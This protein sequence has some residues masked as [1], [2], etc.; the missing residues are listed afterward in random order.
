MGVNSLTRDTLANTVKYNALLAGNE[1]GDI[2]LSSDFLIQ[3]VVL[4]GTAAT[5]I[6]DVSTLAS[7]YKHLQ[8]RAIQRDTSSSTGASGTWFW[9]NGDTGSN[10]SWHRLKGQSGAVGSDTA[11]STTRILAGVGGR[12]GNSGNIYGVTICDILDFAST[13]KYKTTRGLAADV[14]ST[15]EIELTSGNWRS[16]SAITTVGIA[17]DNLFMAGSRFSLYGS[18][19]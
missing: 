13:S 15:A 2:A 7:T 4:N 14:N 18:K 8:I 10:Y 16:T 11:T 3:E 12:N 17:A 9:F 19:G 5:V 6:F 1:T